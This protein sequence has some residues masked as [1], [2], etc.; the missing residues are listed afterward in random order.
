[1]LLDDAYFAVRSWRRRP[2]AAA[3]AIA[4][5]AIGIGAATSIYSVVD[6]VLLRPL[7]L[8][9]ARRI[10]AIMQTYPRWRGNQI[11]ASMWDHLP[12]SQPEFRDLARMQTAFSSVAIWTG[13]G[14]VHSIDDRVQ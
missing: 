7:P 4:T 13:G 8:P 11:L 1:V 5:I 10:V 6:G 2:A 14:N 3:I 9:E 12:L